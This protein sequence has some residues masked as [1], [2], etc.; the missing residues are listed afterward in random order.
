MNLNKYHKRIINIAK[1]ISEQ[2]HFKFAGIT[3]FDNNT[4]SIYFKAFDGNKLVNIHY[5]T[6]HDY[7]WIK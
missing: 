3:K 5:S 4:H 6:K 7:V 2:Y 1:G